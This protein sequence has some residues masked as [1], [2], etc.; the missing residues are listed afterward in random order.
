MNACSNIYT[1]FS[2]EFIL[3][4]AE[5]APSQ[6]K[7]LQCLSSHSNPIGVSLQLL[8]FEP[9][10][11]ASVSADSQSVSNT[12]S[13]QKG[14][15]T[16]FRHDASVLQARLAAASPSAATIMLIS[17][18]QLTGSTFVALAG[19]EKLRSI[20][21]AQQF[22]H[23]SLT[24]RS[25]TG[26]CVGSIGVCYRLLMYTPL[27]VHG[28]LTAVTASSGAAATEH[29]DLQINDPR[30]KGRS[31]A[32]RKYEE[33]HDFPHKQL[34]PEQQQQ[35]LQQERQKARARASREQQQQKHQCRQIR[36]Q[37]RSLLYTRSLSAPSSYQHCSSMRRATVATDRGAYRNNRD[38][39]AGFDAISWTRRR[40][41]ALCSRCGGRT[42]QRQIPST[43]SGASNNHDRPAHDKAVQISDLSPGRF[44]QTSDTNV[45]EVCAFGAQQ[46]TEECERVEQK[47]QSNFNTI[48]DMSAGNLEG[49][50]LT[51][52]SGEHNADEPATNVTKESNVGEACGI[53]KEESIVAREEGLS[54]EDEYE[55]EDFHSDEDKE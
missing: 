4:D 10:L 17:G 55:A 41:P 8:D 33:A 46:Q 32:H 25:A 43:A 2:L 30:L 53:E 5:L 6:F 20:S 18:A 21:S 31:T 49:Q 11:L 19:L 40:P 45:C 13:F 23:E 47:L 44:A 15:C 7:Q 9:V 54:A 22:V 48:V 14:K 28:G 52:E 38:R 36:S 27:P 16:L 12:I 3:L 29:D 50:S 34:Q 24:L 51:D 42:A 39:S 35:H 1:V 37:R 26:A